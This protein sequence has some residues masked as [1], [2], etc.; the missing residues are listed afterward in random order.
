MK[1]LILI[2][3]ALFLITACSKEKKIERNLWK[4]GGQWD[5]VKY[6]EIITSTSPEN[7]K[8]E[9]IEN[10]GIFQ[11]EKNGEGFMINK[12]EYFAEKI[13]F[14]YD[15]TATELT[16]DFYPNSYERKFELDWNKNSFILTQN[17]TST[18]TDENGNPLTLN[19]VTFRYTCKKN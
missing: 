1:Y 11:F 15:N 5:I 10:A 18:Y 19:T 14:K 16:L 12:E 13:N 7:E 9:T 6:E 2:S 4:N 3:T 17:I 8:H